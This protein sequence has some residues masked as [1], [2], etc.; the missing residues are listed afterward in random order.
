VLPRRCSAT[1]WRWGTELRFALE[2]ADDGIEVGVLGDDVGI[3]SWIGGND[4]AK[5][6]SEY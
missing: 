3:A 5:F 1:F 6:Q 4:S 2:V